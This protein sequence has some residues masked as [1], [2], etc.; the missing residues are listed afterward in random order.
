MVDM[1]MCFL[2]ESMDA[3]GAVR[4]MVMSPNTGI[5]MMNAVRDGASSM[6]EKNVCFPKDSDV[7]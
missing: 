2:L 4:T 7:L 5:D 1:E 3:I 6:H